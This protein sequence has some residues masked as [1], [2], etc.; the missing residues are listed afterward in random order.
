MSLRNR[1]LSAF[2]CRE[3]LYEYMTDN[4]DE[5]RKSA[6]ERHLES[7]PQAQDELR[8]LQ[9]ALKFCEKLSQVRLSTTQW[10][11][12][13]SGR[14]RW[15]YFIR[16]V[17]PNQWPI[18]VRLTAEALLISIVVFTIAMFIPWNKLTTTFFESQESVELIQ[19]K[20]KSVVVPPEE[21][22]LQA[23]DGKKNPI[24]PPTNTTGNTSI[25]TENPSQKTK[26][27]T[28]S[29]PMEI[30][31]SEKTSSPVR[32]EKQKGEQSETNQLPSKR[33]D[34]RCSL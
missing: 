33:T 11:E 27:V 30:E 29:P 19:V 12:I 31:I 3:L 18:S 28:K 22:S 25:Q 4:L 21:A 24:A 32:P 13:I 23:M 16:F 26:I 9:S 5:Q 20:R 17:L 2:M 14:N 8:N 34:K 15:T 7:N 6:V 10:E 1:E